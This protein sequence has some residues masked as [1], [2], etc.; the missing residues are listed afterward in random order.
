MP[1]TDFEP[2]IVLGLL[3]YVF[4]AWGLLSDIWSD[5]TASRRAKIGSTLGALAMVGGL[6]ILSLAGLRL[7][8]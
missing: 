3:F 2:S 6:L 4:L 5:K 1:P 7:S 8:Q